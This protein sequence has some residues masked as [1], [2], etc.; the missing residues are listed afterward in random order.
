MNI[1][2]SLH[3]TLCNPAWSRPRLGPAASQ[4]LQYERLPSELK[5]GLAQSAAYQFEVSGEIF[6]NA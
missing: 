1:L 5:V 4:K 6:T 2:L 3:V